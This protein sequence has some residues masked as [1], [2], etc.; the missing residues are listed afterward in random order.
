MSTRRRVLVV[1]D[2]PAVAKALQV[3]LEVHDIPCVTVASPAEALELVDREELGAVLQDMNF[4]PSDTD[5]AAGLELF[6]TLRAIDPELPVLALTAWASLET[7]VSMVKEGAVDYLAKPWDDAKLVATVR[8]LMRMRDLQ[9]ENHRLRAAQTRDR[10]R[11]EQK[12][13]LRGLVYES[14]AMGRVVALA[15]QVAA[16]DVPVLITGPNGVG[17]EMIADIVQA[18]SRRKAGPWVKVNAG[19]LPD[20]LLEA[21]LFGAEQG[22][23]TGAVKRRIGR[24]EAADRGTI[25]LDEIGNLSPG[26]QAKLL[27]VLQSGSFERLGSSEPRTVDVRVIAATNVDL[28]AAMADG[29]F[30]EDLFFRLSVI[31][32]KIPPLR[33]RA[34]DVMPLADG[35]LARFAGDAPR[36]FTPEARAALEDHAW[37]GNVRE[38]QNR[39]QR[40]VL[41]GSPAITAADLDLA[42]QI[43]A[44]G[45]SD[46]KRQLEELLIECGGM[47]SKVAARVGIT[48]QS[49]YRRME[50]LGISLE[51]RPK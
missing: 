42:A 2:Q 19:A 47:V 32:I 13:D 17:K 5:G 20:A 48:R 49:L 33:E 27:R 45:S 41:I 25:F 18:N 50:R 24:F 12:H 31:E 46:E 39:V 40:A 22:A 34:E 6:R 38:L 21:E 7:A 28:T 35:F 37:P 11:L 23:F 16:S 8:N 15:T 10:R 9:L 1:E 51:R 36:S 30:R 26:G 44:P 3:L 43:A 4:G 14:A 29:R